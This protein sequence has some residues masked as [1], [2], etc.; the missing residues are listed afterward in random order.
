MNVTSLPRPSPILFVVL[1]LG[2]LA[3]SSEPSTPPDA[4]AGGH[5]GAGTGGHGGEPPDA[6]MPDPTDAVFDPTH[7]LAIEIDLA[8]ADWETLR[9]QGRSLIDE[10]GEGCQDGPKPSPF[11]KF[12]ATVTVDG[13]KLPMSTVRKKGFFGSASLSRP[14]LKVDFDDDV[15]GREYSGVEG[16]TLNNSKQDPS[17][18]KTC[19]ALQL[20]RK[21]GVPASRCNFATV[22]VNGAP[23][24]VYV[25]VEPV[26][27]SFL[28]GHFAD[29]TGNLYEGQLSDLRPGFSATYQKKTNEGDPDRSDLD[30]VS[31]ALSASDGELE[32]TLGKVLDLDAFT[33]FWAM[34]SLLAAWDGYA[35]NLNNHFIYHDPTSQK[36]MFI[37]WGPDMSFDEDDPF[38]PQD[39]PQ[40]VSAK[41]GV[42]HR[43]YGAP[44]F[45]QKYVAEMKS[46]LDTVWKEDE[47]LAEI[48]RIQ[49]LLAP[50]LGP[51]AAAAAKAAGGVRAFVK[52]RRATILGELSP[53]P[54][55]WPYP[56]P[57]GLCLT[58]VATV[59][60]TFS[61]TFGTLEDPNPF[62]T[63]TGTFDFTKTGEAT[64]D[65]TT[66]GAAAGD[67]AG[68]KGRK[69]VNVVGQFPDGKFRALVFQ[70]DPEVFAPGKDALYDWQSIFA[71]G[72]DIP[73]P[74]KS[75]L[76]GLFGG[77]TFHFDQASTASGGKVSG[78]FSATI[79]ANPFQ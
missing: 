22:K 21:A 73:A 54:P 55:S 40:S 56:P 24:G 32:A 57:A 38:N 36:M 15:P 75:K 23:M 62:M 26:K 71:L 12:S 34:E 20:F 11:T 69:Q 2:A 13:T 31:A 74:G 70:I 78:S 58:T 9:F 1:A 45:Q 6:S 76:S 14:S 60:G 67:M 63:G 77:G 10:L 35:N 44:A 50:H 8:P 66:V 29:A 37:P 53:K 43:L 39:R 72:V 5:G 52:N 49:A 64:L 61:T 48:D 41:G 46:L 65:A 17:L 3:C 33:R 42:A 47:I 30:A 51:G 27:K 19:L 4:G 16:L 7:V 79:L 18:V 25:N 28:A 68:E 59:S